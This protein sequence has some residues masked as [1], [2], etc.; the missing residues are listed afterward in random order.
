MFN[1]PIIFKFNSFICS[2]IAL[3]ISQRSN[4]R[5]FR[6][7]IFFIDLCSRLPN[8]MTEIGLDLNLATFLN[9]R[10]TRFTFINDFIESLSSTTCDNHLLI[11]VY[12]EYANFISPDSINLWRRNN[13][14]CCKVGSAGKL[15]IHFVASFVLARRQIFWSHC[16]RTCL[17]IYFGVFIRYCPHIF[18]NRYIVWRLYCLKTTRLLFYINFV[19]ILSLASKILLVLSNFH[20]NSFA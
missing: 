16:L 7:I 13:G 9:T 8:I 17:G 14:V 3:N 20:I 2:S 18:W 12:I 1:L 5:T 6:E 15:R 4:I 19:F 10:K 11:L